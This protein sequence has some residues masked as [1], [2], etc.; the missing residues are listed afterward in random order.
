[1]N[2]RTFLISSGAESVGALLSTSASGSGAGP[3]SAERLSWNSGQLQ[4]E[5]SVAEGRLR[6]H[7]ILP[8][9]VEP[10]N[11]SQQWAG[12]ESAPLCSGEDSPDSGMKQSAGS[13]GQR[14]KFVAKDERRSDRGNTLVL[15]HTDSDLHLDLESHYEAFEGLSVVRRHVEISNT[16]KETVGIEYLSSAMLHALADPV[17][18]DRR[19][20]RRSF[21][22]AK[23]GMCSLSIKPGELPNWH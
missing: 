5:F 22:T 1:M 3:E 9:G 12:I 11:E 4:I 23:N 13:P 21:S 8:V 7:L 18:Y 17:H 19:R 16:G 20:V 14:L 10:P 2:R 15:R 6:Q